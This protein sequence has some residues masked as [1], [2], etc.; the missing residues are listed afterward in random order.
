MVVADVSQETLEFLLDLPE[1]VSVVGIEY[2]DGVV[3]LSLT[4]E[5]FDESVDRVELQ[6]AADDYGNVGLRGISPV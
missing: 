4:S 5:L 2:A 3:R 1:G 6:Y